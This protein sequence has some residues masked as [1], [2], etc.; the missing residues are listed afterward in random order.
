MTYLKIGDRYTNFEYLADYIR[1]TL[2]IKL[3]NIKSSFYRHIGKREISHPMMIW[4][5]PTNI[6]NLRCIMC[7][8]GKDLVKRKKGHMDFNLYRKII[9]EACRWKP[10]INLHHMGE[11]LLYPK[12]VDM[13]K[14]AK[15]KKCGPVK[16]TTNGTVLNEKLALSILDSGLDV[17]RF[18][19]DGAT[20]KTYEKI[21]IG[22]DFDKTLG[23]ITDFIKLKKKLGKKT[24]IIVD[25]VVIDKNKDEVD[26]FV[27]KFK[28]L[29][30]DT[31]HVKDPNNW[32]GYVDVADKGKRYI[33]CRHPY[34]FSTITWDGYV[35]PCCR[36][37]DAMYKI[38]NI[39]ED[40]LINI[41]NNKRM[42]FLREAVAS[43]KS[44]RINICKNCSELYK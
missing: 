34:H 9:D 20:K 39:S 13:I 6:C 38:G 36:D 18:S 19:F 28:K 41:W 44:E 26:L 11:S 5:E 1:F 10:Y 40:K 14:Y 25:I 33:G 2:R 32:G 15:L 31:V 30:V 27:E 12:I 35:I 22:S 17:I 4:I 43:K 8:Q 23:Y 29:G 21:R 24:Q 37:F 3:R 7:P 42:H 16:L